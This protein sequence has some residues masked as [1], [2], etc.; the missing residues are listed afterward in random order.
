LRQGTDPSGA[1]DPGSEREFLSGQ[2]KAL[3]SEL[4]AIQK[5]LGELACGA[6]QG[7]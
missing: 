3:Q 1:V 7:S 5:R 6:A 4:D 2:A